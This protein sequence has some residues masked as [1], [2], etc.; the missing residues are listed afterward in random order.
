MRDFKVY[1][2]SGMLNFLV[3]EASDVRKKEQTLSGDVVS[4]NADAQSPMKIVVDVDS[5]GWTACNISAMGLNITRI[6]S[7][8]SHPDMDMRSS[9]GGTSALKYDSDEMAYY[10]PSHRQTNFTVPKTEDYI[11]SFYAKRRQGISGSYA[12]LGEGNV[13]PNSPSSYSYDDFVRYSAK[14]HKTAGSKITLTFYDTLFLKD[15]QIEFSFDSS[16]TPSDYA[17]YAGSTY[18]LQFPPEAG[19]VTDGTVTVLYDGSATLETGGQT[20][21]L[22]SVSPI[23]TLIGD[24]NIWADTGDVSVTYPI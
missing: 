20:Y 6:M 9:G 15:F 8:P 7:D 22:T 10:T 14:L 2:T 12:V 13:F 4:F 16:S 11:V 18:N 5:T 21:Q 1:Q 24:N 3:S 17:S 19:A 23:E